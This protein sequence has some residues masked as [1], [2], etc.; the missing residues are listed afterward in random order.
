MT[1]R[2]QTDQEL[3]TLLAD[4]QAEK[5]RR[6]GLQKK[7]EQLKEFVQKIGLEAIDIALMYQEHLPQPDTKKSAKKKAK[8]ENTAPVMVSYSYE[9][10]DGET[11]KVSRKEGA[12]GADSFFN[13]V[14]EHL[15]LK[16]LTYS[17]VLKLHLT[18]TGKTYIESKFAEYKPK[19][20][21]AK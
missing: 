9:T 8:T 20:S 1:L 3:A 14:K 18:P 11:V 12:R 13:T 2:T 17:D 21:G 7:F 6:D 15:D 4:A 19:K 16:I 10:E 5:T